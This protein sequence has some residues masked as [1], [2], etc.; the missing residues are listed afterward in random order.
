MSPGGPSAVIDPSFQRVGHLSLNISS[1]NKTKFQLSDTLY[2]LDGFVEM[3]VRCY[4][5]NCGTV[6]CRGFLVSFYFGKYNSSK[7]EIRR[8]RRLYLQLTIRDL[9]LCSRVRP[10]FPPDLLS[11]WVRKFSVLDRAAIWVFPYFTLRFRH[12]VLKKNESAV[13]ISNHLFFS[14]SISASWKHCFMDTLLVCALGWPTTI[15]AISWR[16]RQ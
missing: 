8:S 2:P 6:G 16:W 10:P 3:K 11:R 4:A 12:S 5:E 13:K 1:V 14:E 9:L 15:L 7:Y